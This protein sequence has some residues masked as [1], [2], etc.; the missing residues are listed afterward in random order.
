M[1]SNENECAI[2]GIRFD[3]DDALKRLQ[4]RL[5]GEGIRD[6]KVFLNPEITPT[7]EKLREEIIAIFNSHLDGESKPYSLI[8]DGDVLLKHKGPED[9]SQPKYY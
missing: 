7:M 2:R 1:E 4:N 6:I 9:P 3:F 8:S 5:D